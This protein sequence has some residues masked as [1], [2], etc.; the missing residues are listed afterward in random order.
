[1]SSKF[2]IDFSKMKTPKSCSNLGVLLF[3][4]VLNTSTLY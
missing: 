4:Y 3:F 1:M 2:F